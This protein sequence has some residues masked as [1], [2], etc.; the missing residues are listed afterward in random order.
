VRPLLLVPASKPAAPLAKERMIANRVLPAISL[1]LLSCLAACSSTSG[2]ERTGQARS[3]VINGKPSDSSQDSVV[4]LVH[5]DPTDRSGVGQCTGTL[6][7]PRLVLTARHCV[8]DTD[9]YAA[10]K[11][12]GTPIMAGA[13]R[14]NHK[15]DTMYVFTGKDRP[16]FGRAQDIEPAGQGMKILD[17]GG[18]NLCNHDIALIVLKEP[19][20]NV[21]IAPVRL[22]GDVEVGE[23][24]TAVGWGV[25]EDTPSPDQ[26]QQRKNIK[27]TNVGPDKSA[28]NVPPNEF[29][30]GESICSGDSGGPGFAQE[31]NAVIGV[32]SRG[33]NAGGGAESN[34]PA[35]NCIDG[36]NLYTKTS[37]FKDLI[38][39]GFELAEAEPWI[40]GGPDP[41]KLKPK[42]ACASGDE[43]RSALCLPDPDAAN[44][45]TCAED[46]S[47]TETCS[48]EGEVC[49]AEGDSKVCRKPAPPPAEA[50]A[51]MCAS[52][53][54]SSGGGAFASVIFGLLALAGLRRKR[55]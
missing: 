7:A 38:L 13:I 1:T 40:E 20:T 4:L 44:E 53:P 3:A 52:A 51:G 55:S 5:Y 30:V 8:G 26:R 48:V 34:D 21:P 28:A 37:P 43:C 12:D 41:R 45:T 25:T 33:G 35:A 9:A 24:I 47:V 10:C 54:A 14:K 46:C 42:A 22:D 49:T 27:I 11:A 39:Q 32:V 17:D 19:I 36:R 15:A 6:L 18:K 50:S 16:D 29:E 23:L 2:E 31:T